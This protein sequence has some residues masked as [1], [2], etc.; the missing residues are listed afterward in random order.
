ML[1]LIFIKIVNIIYKIIYFL[2]AVSAISASTSCGISPAPVPVPAVTATVSVPVSCASVTVSNSGPYLVIILSQ[3]C[4]AG[5]LL[6]LASIQS[7]SQLL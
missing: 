4:L 7:V 5:S 1:S 3:G 6:I 2:T